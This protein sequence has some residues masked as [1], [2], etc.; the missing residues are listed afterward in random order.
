MQKENKRKGRLIKNQPDMVCAGK[1]KTRYLKHL[2]G[3][4]PPTCM[5][6][7][8]EHSSEDCKSL[9]KFGKIIWNLGQINK[10]YVQII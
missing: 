3:E 1:C 6:N 8:N 10:S 7:G 4:W 9:R 5:I 2:R